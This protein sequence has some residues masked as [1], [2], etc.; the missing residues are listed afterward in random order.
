MFRH[1]MT[2]MKGKGKCKKDEG[3]SSSSHTQSD[4]FPFLFVVIVLF[5]FF[6]IYTRSYQFIVMFS[7]TCLMFLLSGHSGLLA[8]TEVASCG[9]AW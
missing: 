9:G 6:F 3:S 4:M 2:K 5:P 7:L 1:L 8:A